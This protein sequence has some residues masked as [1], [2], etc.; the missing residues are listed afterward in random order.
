MIRAL[1]IDLDGVLRFFDSERETAAEELGGLPA[2]SIRRAAFSKELLEPAITGH[3]CDER[4]REQIVERLRSQFPAAAAR[5]AVDVW[6]ES[7]GRI[8][9][10]VLDLVR[11]CRHSVCVALVTNATSRL[12]ADLARLRVDSEFDHVFNSAEL[13]L[14]K[15]DP[16]L[17]ERIL[18]RIG[19]AAR[20]VCFVDDNR[21]HVSAAQSLGIAGHCYVGIAEL[22]A[23]LMQLGINERDGTVR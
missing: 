2:G 13:G 18:A 12:A 10:P 16:R 19:L 7:P 3:V 4:W 14:I 22:R 17:F 1:L 8:D 21:G 20:T 11:R 15:P 5:E 9:W 23:A 6:S